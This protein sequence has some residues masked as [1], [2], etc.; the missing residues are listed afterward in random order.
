MSS[1]LTAAERALAGDAFYRAAQDTDDVVRG[2]ALLGLGHL[3][4]SDAIDLMLRATRDREW[5]T[6]LSAAVALSWLRPPAGLSEIASLLGDEEG[7][8]RDQAKMILQQLAKH[9]EDLEIRRFATQALESA[10]LGLD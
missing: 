4:R 6:R 2:Q 9:S 1:Q 3:Q 7:L 10:R 8:V 5:F